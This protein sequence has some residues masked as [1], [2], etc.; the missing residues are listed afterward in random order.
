M[1]M[2]EAADRQTKMVETR[3]LLEEFE[4]N[5]AQYHKFRYLEEQ[6]IK[7][8]EGQIARASRYWN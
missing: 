4:L 8:R 1:A 3:I 2:T 6:E 7:Q 5:P